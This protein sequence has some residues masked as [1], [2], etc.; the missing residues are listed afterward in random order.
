MEL[1]MLVLQTLVVLLLV[2]ISVQNYL[3]I[4]GS[5]LAFSYSSRFDESQL[6]KYYR[7][8]QKYLETKDVEITDEELQLINTTEELLY[9]LNMVFN[10]FE[11]ISSAY[12]GGFLDKKYAF[13]AF[14]EPIFYVYKRYKKRIDFVRKESGD[15]SLIN[16]LEKAF[17]VMNRETEKEIRRR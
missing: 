6:D 10:C 14:S 2:V 9:S 17:Y 3:L 16:Q 11:D 1:L 15:L 7:T 8:I 4:K 5:K 13:I 12:N